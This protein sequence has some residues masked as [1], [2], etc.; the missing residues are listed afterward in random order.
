MYEVYKLN[1]PSVA[2]YLFQEAGAKEIE[3]ERNRV[4][5]WFDGEALRRFALLY[6]KEPHSFLVRGNVPLEACYLFAEVRPLSWDAVAVSVIPFP[7][8]DYPLPPNLEAL[9]AAALEPEGV[10]VKVGEDGDIIH[11][12]VQGERARA[13]LEDWLRG[14]TEGAVEL[15]YWLEGEVRKVARE[16][17]E[18][19][20]LLFTPQGEAAKTGMGVHPLFWVEEE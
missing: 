16:A 14:S 6:H 20:Q 1:A 17:I 10:K 8:P 4:S 9:L 13:V 2:L 11:L 3:A 12:T 7:L 15:A 19:V 18:E 5:G